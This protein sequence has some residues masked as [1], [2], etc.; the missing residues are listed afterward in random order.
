MHDTSSEHKLLQVESN[1]VSSA[2][3]KKMVIPLFDPWHQRRCVVTIPENVKTRIY[4]K[5]HGFCLWASDGS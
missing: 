3:S 5:D 1:A 4:I 2:W